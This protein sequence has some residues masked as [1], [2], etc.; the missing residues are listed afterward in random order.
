[1]GGNRNIICTSLDSRN[2]MGNHSRIGNP[3]VN[4]DILSPSSNKTSNLLSCTGSI[5]KFDTHV[6]GSDTQERNLESSFIEEVGVKS[7]LSEIVKEFDSSGQMNLAN[8]VLREIPKFISLRHPTAETADIRS[9]D[10]A[11]STRAKSL[12]RMKKENERDDRLG[13]T[14]DFETMS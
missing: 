8:S 4:K 1:M 12:Y 6:H 7:I 13:Y 5:E 3:G 10:F 9:I 11:T 2:S 14:H